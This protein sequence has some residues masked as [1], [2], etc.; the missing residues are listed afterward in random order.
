MSIKRL[1]KITKIAPLSNPVANKKMGIAP[2]LATAREFASCKESN[3]LHFRRK[4]T[5]K[6]GRMKNTQ[7]ATAN[8]NKNIEKDLD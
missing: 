3:Q 8:I 1:Y 5:K 2:I 7:L 6:Y 4:D